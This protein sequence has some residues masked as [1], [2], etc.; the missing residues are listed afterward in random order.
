M[1]ILVTLPQ[2]HP[3]TL[4]HPYPPIQLTQLHGIPQFLHL[5]FHSPF[6]PALSLHLSYPSI[7]HSLP[8]HPSIFMFS[9]S[10][11]C[12][13]SSLHVTSS[14]LSIFLH[15]S[16]HSS[17]WNP[18]GFLL[19]PSVSVHFYLIPPSLSDTTIS[20]SLLYLLHPSVFTS[21]SFTF[22]TSPSS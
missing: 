4:H 5:F 7:L 19:P 13:S 1:F 2:Q 22:F 3:Y 12:T 15:Q 11:I 17:P 16:N 14:H 20:T 6:M 21:S 10:Y 8:L 18:S 9:S